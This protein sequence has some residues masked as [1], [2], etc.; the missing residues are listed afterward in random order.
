[1][2][3]KIGICEHYSGQVLVDAKVKY[4][5]SGY[6]LHRSATGTKGLPHLETISR[7]TYAKVYTGETAGTKPVL[8]VHEIAR[9]LQG[10]IAPDKL[11]LT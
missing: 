3:F 2:A 6:A 11:V 8:H 9:L 1:M 10:L 4:E 7:M 5:C